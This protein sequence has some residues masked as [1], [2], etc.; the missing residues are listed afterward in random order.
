MV[1]QNNVLLKKIPENLRRKEDSLCNFFHGTMIFDCLKNDTGIG[2]F[3]KTQKT[4]TK[5]ITN[6][7]LTMYAGSSA[8]IISRYRS[9]LATSP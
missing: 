4:I 8:P 5:T 9:G 3:V 7:S 2:I 6:N 1:T